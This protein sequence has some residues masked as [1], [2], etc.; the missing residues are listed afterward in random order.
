[1]TLSGGAQ[2]QGGGEAEL[3]AVIE[4]VEQGFRLTQQRLREQVIPVASSDGRLA[5]SVN[6]EGLAVK[7]AIDPTLL[8]DGVCALEA[9]VMEAVNNTALS[10][11]ALTTAAF[12][13]A[14]AECLGLVIPD[15]PP[16]SPPPRAAAGESGR[17]AGRN[18]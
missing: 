2:A 10:V 4:R 11:H 7:V 17:R 8:A 1:V 9:A 16:P 5:L 6:G 18:P 13:L 15:V 3:A 12:Q 14:T